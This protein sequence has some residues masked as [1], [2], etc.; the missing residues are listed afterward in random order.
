MLHSKSMI[1]LLKIFLMFSSVLLVRCFFC[2]KIQ[3]RILILFFLFF[4]ISVFSQSLKH[5]EIIDQQNNLLF[6]ESVN[7]EIDSVQAVLTSFFYTYDNSKK[8]SL[9]LANLHAFIFKSF[10][11]FS[12][13]N[14]GHLKR[15]N[16]RISLKKTI[17]GNDIQYLNKSFNI[18]LCYNNLYDFMILKFDKILKVNNVNFIRNY[19]LMAML[20]RLY[21]FNLNYDT[22]IENKK[23][24]RI[25]N[26]KDIAYTSKRNRLKKLSKKLLGRM[27]YNDIKKHIRLTNNAD[28][29]VL[30]KKTHKSIDEKKY[31]KSKFKRDYRKLRYLYSQDAL[32]NTT[33]FVTQN[34]SGV[35]GN[36]IG[37]FHFRKGYLYQNDSVINVV[38][39][40]LK[41]M[42]ILLEKT[43]FCLTDKFI[44]GYF[45]H[46][47]IWLGTA[48]ELKQMG[49]WNSPFIKLYHNQI[50]AGNCILETNR[51][52]THLTN[53]SDFMNVDA[54]AIVAYKDFDKMTPLLQK[55][56]YQNAF[57]QLGKSYDFNFDVENSKNLFCSELIYLTFGNVD[58]QVHE[59]FNR[60]TILPDDIMHTLKQKNTPLYFSLYIKANKDRQPI[61]ESTKF[62]EMMNE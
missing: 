50:L 37:M 10:S 25:F 52:G 28:Y 17:S 54:V 46:V 47:A 57:S 6:I 12:D 48:S 7:A 5:N 14:Q 19:K 58:W 41:P 39:K 38:K 9:N 8:D 26:I 49:L 18:F 4:Q 11:D 22:L 45:G 3:G 2:L 21:F 16:N 20:R 33:R 29:F 32:F 42:D 1:L 43:E 51:S 23:I 61:D 34:L 60:F 35:F 40:K 55:Q 27:Y 15:I 44:P 30:D 62:A 36:F 53:L 59:K 31:N 56:M 24:R 13:F